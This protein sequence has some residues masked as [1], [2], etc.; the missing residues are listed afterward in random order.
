VRDYQ[1]WE[2]S[3]DKAIFTYK[4]VRMNATLPH[5]LLLLL[6]FSLLAMVS[7]GCANQGTEE[8]QTAKYPDETDYKGNKKA[9]YK[10]YVSSDNYHAF[11][12]AK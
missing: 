8:N 10:P 7:S 4:E 11:L 3:D 2:I 12:D 6:T 9:K 1:G 5:K